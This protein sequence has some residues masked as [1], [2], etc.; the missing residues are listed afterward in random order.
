MDYIF[1]LIVSCR[2]VSGVQH[3]LGFVNYN[4]MYQGMIG[5]LKLLQGLKVFDVTG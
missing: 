2:V 1:C 5:N 3:P 4:S